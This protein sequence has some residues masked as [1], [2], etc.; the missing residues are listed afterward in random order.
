MAQSP[1]VESGERCRLDRAPRSGV[2]ERRIYNG[3]GSSSLAYLRAMPTA[4]DGGYSLTEYASG[5]GR[6]HSGLVRTEPSSRRLSRCSTADSAP[7]GIETPPRPSNLPPPSIAR[8]D[9]PSTGQF[10]LDGSRTPKL[11]FSAEPPDSPCSYETPVKEASLN[12]NESTGTIPVNRSG[13]DADRRS[14][15][16]TVRDSLHNHNSPQSSSRRDESAE[17][18]SFPMHALLVAEDKRASGAL[19][20]AEAQTDPLA[21]ILV[22]E[23]PPEPAEPL[24]V[25]PNDAKTTDGAKTAAGAKNTNDAGSDNGRDTVIKDSS[26][27]PS[28]VNNAGGVD[29]NPGK[30]DAGSNTTPAS[31]PACVD[32]S[33]AG[34]NDADRADKSAN[35]KHNAT[36]SSPPSN[37]NDGL[38][39]SSHK[40]SL[41]D[42][43]SRSPSRYGPLSMTA[44]MNEDL[45]GHR[46]PRR[47][48]HGTIPHHLDH[49]LMLECVMA[50]AEERTTSPTRKYV[51]YSDLLSPLMMLPGDG[52]ALPSAFSRPWSVIL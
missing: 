41:D 52:I 36:K 17:V 2:S 35:S 19:H 20:N 28:S 3:L 31:N 34:T 6:S 14:R 42:C 23:P 5:F 48:L 8:G 25:V 46:V 29:D 30:V 44:G 12:A 50:L 16:Q 49:N 22:D 32:A 47:M 39:G 26:A 33:R 11:P 13:D 15:H 51:H 27:V 24:P 45:A 9:C 10:F 37:R 18:A 1:P 21:S 4:K 43:R 7:I 38:Y 40:D